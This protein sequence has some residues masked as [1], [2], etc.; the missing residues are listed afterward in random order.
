MARLLPGEHEARQRIAAAVACW[1]QLCV[2]AGGPGTGKTTTVA[3]LLACWRINRGRPPRIALAAPTGKAA[4]RLGQAVLAEVAAM[5]LSDRRNLEGVRALTLHRLLGWQPKAGQR[6]RHTAA[7]PLPYDVIV[8]DETSM[9]SLTMMARLFDAVRPSTKVVLVGD[10]DQ[11]ASVEAGAVLADIVARAATAAQDGVV[12]SAGPFGSLVADD[13]AQLDHVENQL[14]RRGVVRLRHRF[15]FGGQ[16]AEL[17]DAV[18]AGDGDAAVAVL[19]RDTGPDTQVR[20]I[21]TADEGE[22]DPAASVRAILQA[23]RA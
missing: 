17:A 8:V 20:L 14:A 12:R 16:I 5:Q 7:D 22:S 2:V 1:R 10:P 15:R 18:V 19:T 4:A 6:Y 23:P 13:L 9:V 11:L 3:R 21:V